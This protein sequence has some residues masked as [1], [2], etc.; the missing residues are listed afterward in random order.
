MDVILLICLIV[1]LFIRV[2][3]YF[4]IKNTGD[5]RFFVPF[6]FECLFVYPYIIVDVLNLQ[7]SYYGFVSLYLLSLSIQLGFI[8]SSKKIEK[9]AILNITYNSNIYY[10]VYLFMIVIF[11]NLFLSHHNIWLI[12]KNLNNIFTIANENAV[13]RYSGNLNVSF[14]YKLSTILSFTL[15]FVIGSLCAIKWN[16]N[17]K[18]ILFLFLLLL[19]IDSVVMAARAGLLLQSAAILSSFIVFKYILNDIQ[20]FKLSVKKILFL[21]LFGLFVFGYFLIVQVFRGGN[22]NFSILPIMSHVLTWFI[23]YIP[24][25]D[26][27]LLNYYNFDLTYGVRTFSGIADA[28]NINQRV[29]GVYSMVYIGQYRYTNIFTAFRGIIEDFSLFGSYFIMFISAYI[30]NISIRKALLDKKIIYFVVSICI[31]YFYLWFFVI[32]P[33]I[34]N[35]ILVSVF[36]YFIMLRFY[37]KVNSND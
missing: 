18:I 30:L 11:I 3:W 31:M 12:F 33:F 34:Y 23:G 5:I 15:S 17:N 1:I 2:G 21:I 6:Y 4:L 24:G 36:I 19:L 35:T 7:W 16:K 25:Y 13:A 28:L 22:E 37:F 14:F 8:L 10:I 26:V 32:N 20:F 9:K 27:W 29:G